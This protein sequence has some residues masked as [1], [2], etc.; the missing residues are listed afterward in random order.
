M[1]EQRWWGLGTS[2]QLAWVGTSLI[3]YVIKL[4]FPFSLLFAIAD[5]CEVV[6]ANVSGFPQQHALLACGTKIE[7]VAS[8]GHSQCCI[9]CRLQH[10]DGLITE[11]KG[12]WREGDEV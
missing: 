6:A 10:P 3:K 9:Q 4:L 5:R 1:I 12:V 11:K 2:G 8:D 7:S